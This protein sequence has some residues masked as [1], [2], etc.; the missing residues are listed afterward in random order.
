MNDANVAQ[1]TDAISIVNRVD[2]SECRGPLCKHTPHGQPPDDGEAIEYEDGPAIIV[3]WAPVTCD[4]PVAD[5]DACRNGGEYAVAESAV[6]TEENKADNVED[7][8]ENC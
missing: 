2:I 5:D 7:Q 4:V 3:V 6:T 1:V 8:D